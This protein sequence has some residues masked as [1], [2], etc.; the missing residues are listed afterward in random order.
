LFRN[1]SLTEKKK[2]DFLG[3]LGTLDSLKYSLLILISLWGK[4]LTS[5]KR[6]KPALLNKI[7]VKSW[8]TITSDESE[9]M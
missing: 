5:S 1:F 3:I 4:L 9:N 8:S 7:I 6:K 2:L